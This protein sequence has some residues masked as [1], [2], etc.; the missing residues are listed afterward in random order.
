MCFDM[1]DSLTKNFFA[2]Y[3]YLQN[4]LRSDLSVLN[5]FQERERER[6]RERGEGHVPEPPLV[7]CVSHGLQASCIGLQAI[8]I[9]AC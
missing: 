1:R 3:Q 9:L 2:G 4:G 6:E 8:N 5:I 7:L